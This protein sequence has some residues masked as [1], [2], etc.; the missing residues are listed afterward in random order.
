MTAPLM[1]RPK[2]SANTVQ[3]V[4]TDLVYQDAECKRRIVVAT[5]GADPDPGFEVIVFKPDGTGRAR[6]VVQVARLVHADVQDGATR[7]SVYSPTVILVAE[8][9][10]RFHLRPEWRFPWTDGQVTGL[11]AVGWTHASVSDTERVRA[12]YHWARFAL[13]KVIEDGRWE[14]TWRSGLP[15]RLLHPEAP[16][17]VYHHLGRP[18][19]WTTPAGAVVNDLPGGW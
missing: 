2:N 5:G 1:A 18:R 9:T 10:R 13:R 3:I 15:K 4:D 12:N 11:G 17:E 8:S 6:W 14:A 16:S 19:R 7:T